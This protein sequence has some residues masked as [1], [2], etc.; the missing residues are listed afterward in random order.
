MEPATIRRLADLNRAFYA[1]H[2]EAFAD[3]RPRLAAGI[4]RMLAQVAP[5]SAVL[6]VGCGDGKVGRWLAQHTPGIAYLGLDSSAVLLE[7][8]RRYSEQLSVNSDQPSAPTT[9]HRS[10]SFAAADLLDPD[11]FA[12]LSGQRFDWIL[13]FAVFH[14]LPGAGIRLG[15]LKALARRLRPGG[16]LALSS[17]QFTRSERLRQRIVPWSAAG[18]D[19]SEVEPNDYLLSWERKGRRGLRY[20]HLLDEA[21]S[22]ALAARAGLSVV[23]VF[24]A[25]GVTADLADYVVMQC[26]A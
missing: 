14:H 6:E 23:E 5:A 16:W 22:R 25:D 9:V 15:V 19:D 18:F 21:E 2:G 10:L 12:A 20:V 26:E 24:R 11:W 3:A 13:A 17:W 7:R 8:A 4:K 1:E